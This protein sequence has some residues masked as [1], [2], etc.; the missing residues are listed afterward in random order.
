MKRGNTLIAGFLF[1]SIAIFPVSAG[2]E[3]KMKI[4]GPDRSPG[5]STMMIDG[6]KM[7]VDTVDPAQDDSTQLIFDSQ[8]KTMIMADVN[9]RMYNVMDQASLAQLKARM[10]AAKKQMEAQLANMPPEQREMMKK[11][12]AGRMGMA[13]D[14]A[15]KPTKNIV[16]TGKSAS[17]AGYDCQ[18]HEVYSGQKKLRELCVTPW[19]KIKNGGEIKQSLEEMNRFFSAFLDSMKGMMPADEESPFAEIEKLNGFPVIFKEFENGQLFETSTL[20][21][22]SSKDLSADIFKAPKGFTKQSMMEGM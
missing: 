12:M 22:I 13:D 20:Q 19:G 21:S 6:G 14:S 10:D 5:N 7:R 18:I 8:T 3:I 2:T 16:K 15:P 4:T 17:A 11:M 9:Q 1:A